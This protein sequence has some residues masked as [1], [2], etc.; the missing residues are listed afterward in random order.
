MK[1]LRPANP[2]RDW[3]GMHATVLTVLL[4]A[5]LALAGCAAGTGG[6]GGPGAVVVTPGVGPQL[7]SEQAKDAAQQ[8][9]D[10]ANPS[11]DPNALEVIVPVFDPGL[12][13]DSDEWEKQGIYPELRRAESNRFALKMKSALQ[14]S[15]EFGAV[16][17]APN[18]SAT[19][20]LY[21]IGKILQS[22][23]EDV[24]INITVTDISGKQWFSK[25]FSH[26]VKE[27]FH[28]DIRNKNKNND[29]YQPVFDKAAAHIVKQLKKRDAAQL[30]KLRNL[31]EIR[32]GASLSEETF[33]PYLEKAG[34]DGKRV[35]LAAAPADDDPM[36]RRIRAIRVRDQ[37]FLDRMQTHYDTF[38]AKLEKSYL[39]WQQQSFT[40]VKAARAAKRKALTKGILGGVLLV[41]GLAAAQEATDDPHNQSTTG[42]VGGTLAAIGGGIFLASAWGDRAEMKVHREALAEL[43]QSIDIEVAPQVVE[44]EEETAELSGDAAQQYAQW[45]EFLKKIYAIEATP[46]KTL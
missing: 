26:R 38:D 18:A 37:L 40:E 1:F 29:P 16:R 30:A 46:D 19:G 36:L 5:A 12:P 42:A 9:G 14:D 15:G 34:S 8:S 21:V 11:G 39:V 45:I 3:R 28:N 44:F 35:R 31:T 6:L 13:E 25:D 23:G 27:R 2:N 32:F 4:A 24:K 41:A 10:A 22:N 20:D 17:V 33:A 7:S 43:G